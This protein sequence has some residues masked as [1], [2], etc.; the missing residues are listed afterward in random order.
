[1]PEK[2]SNEKIDTIRALGAE[3]VK[4]PN[5]ATSFTEDGPI[6]VSQR[7]RKEIPNSVIL[8]QVI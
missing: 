3:I 2:N 4:T 1:M 7:L 5:S 8:D 6:A